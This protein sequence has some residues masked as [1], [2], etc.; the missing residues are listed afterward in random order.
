MD[1]SKS[2]PSEIDSGNDTNLSGGILDHIQEPFV[3]TICTMES[4]TKYVL[5]VF[6]CH[7]NETVEKVITYKDRCYILFVG[8][9][10]IDDKYKYDER[11]IIV[12]DLKDNIEHE[13][14]LLTFTAWYA[15]IKNDLFADYQYI[16]ILEHDITISDD[17]ESNLLTLCKEN[18]VDCVSFCID[19][20]GVKSFYMWINRMVLKYFLKLKNASVNLE[21][22]KEFFTNSNSCLRRKV[23]ADFVDWYYPACF[24]FKFYHE[25]RFSWYHERL[26]YIYAKYANLKCEYLSGTTHFNNMSYNKTFNKI[27]HTVPK[28]YFLIYNDDTCNHYIEK[29]VSSIK[30]HSDFEVVIFNKSDI[31]AEFVNAN[32]NILDEKRGGGYWLWKPY[33][34]NNMLNKIAHKDML[35]Y[36]DAKYY[37][38]E[39]FINLYTEFMKYSDITL[40]KN[41]PNNPSYN[42]KNWCKMDVIDKY[43]MY[44]AVFNENFSDCWAGAICLRKTPFIEKIMKEWLNMCCSYENITDSPSVISN[45]ADFIEHRHDQ[46]LLGVLVYKYNIELKHFPNKYLQN[47]RWPWL[48]PHELY[49]SVDDAYFHGDTNRDNQFYIYPHELKIINS[50]WDFY[51]NPCTNYEDLSGET[52]G[53]VKT[54]KCLG[55][56]LG[57]KHVNLTEAHCFHGDSRRD[58]NFYMYPKNGSILNEKWDFY[59]NPCTNCEEKPINEWGI[60]TFKCLGHN[61]LKNTYFHGDI[62]RDNNFFI[63]PEN[64]STLNNRWDFYK[65]PCTNCNKITHQRNG[66][67]IY[68]CLGHELVTE[69]RFHG[70]SRRDN[71]FY[72]YPKNIQIINSKWDFHVNPCE[73]Y[74]DINVDTNG[75]KIC[76]C[77][78]HRYVD[79]NFL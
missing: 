8:D 20:A 40:W 33:I 30:T 15:I 61:I 38:T 4:L 27:I 16:C 74:E 34:I 52:S 65:N 70:D 47:C 53:S 54:Y 50:K 10:S 64:L 58:N 67:Q 59:T 48:L 71:N 39:P 51:V 3:N 12:R 35:F 2:P 29:L 11:I 26:I 18:T 62:T 41:H 5:I 7:D 6:V 49:H 23:L 78:G 13:P 36:L 22:H 55:H 9:N 66:V 44:D 19:R 21:E 32:K 75:I 31:D 72:I 14:K 79:K 73:N 63:I 28:K 24:E 45:K 57:T 76:K 43:K 46:S 77:L 69:L 1:S 56:N 68:K 60:S 42:M 25:D 37:F 17:F